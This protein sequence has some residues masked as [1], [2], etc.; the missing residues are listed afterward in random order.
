M[1]VLNNYPLKI[2]HLYFANA[3]SQKYKS[4]TIETY[5]LIKNDK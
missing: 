3:I 2:L 5:Q 1:I 4:K